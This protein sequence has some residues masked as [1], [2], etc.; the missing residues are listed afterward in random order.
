MGRRAA[1]LLFAALALCGQAAAEAP[2]EA[3]IYEF[4]A[5]EWLGGAYRDPAGGGFS[6]CQVDHALA[7]GSR[8]GFGIDR[9]HELV[10]FLERPTWTFEPEAVDGASLR[11]DGRELGR[12]PALAEGGLLAV[13]LGGRRDV[14]GELGR[15]RELELT[16]SG[17]GP[18][19]EP[20]ARVSLAGSRAALARTKECVDLA[21]ALPPDHAGSFADRMTNPFAEGRSPFDSS[22]QAPSRAER[23][24]LEAWR[25]LIEQAGMGPFQFVRP[26]DIAPDSPPAL[27]WQSLEHDVLGLLHLFPGGSVSAED[28]IGLTLMALSENCALGH[29]TGGLPSRRAGRY[30]LKAGSIQCLRESET[31][32]A[33][34]AAIVDPDSVTLVVH[35]AQSE[36]ALFIQEVNSRLLEV[37]AGLLESAEPPS[38]D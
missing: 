2:P 17:A 4:R 37:L 38:G 29:Y 3:L 1:A 27:A 5:G 26:A 32:Y 34:V 30:T 31:I 12:F 28:A 19:T 14:F 33:T 23:D 6:H 8:L 11:V 21:L 16:L 7:D 24:L 15:G 22:G 25:F 13:R 35:I 18:G 20:S 10:L 36:D 9:D